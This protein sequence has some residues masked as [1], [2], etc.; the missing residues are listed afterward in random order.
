MYN[1]LSHSQVSRFQTCPTSYKYYYVEKIR[2][3][4]SKAA[5][6]FGT[7]LDRAIQNLLKPEDQNKNKTPEDIFKYFWRFQ[8]VNG[9]REYLPTLLSLVYAKSDFDEDL[10]TDEV[11]EKIGKSREEILKIIAVR[12]E[13]GY[14]KLSDR[15]KEIA[16]HAFWGCLEQKGL[17]MIEAF[18]NK[19]L[20]K[21][22][23]VLSVQEYICLDNEEGDKVI[24]Y[25]D[26]VVNIQGQDKPVIIDLKTSAMKYDEVNSVIYS[27]QLSLYVHAVGKKY[28]TNKAGYIVLNKHI[29]KNKSK[30]CLSCNFDGSGSR[31]KT[32]FNIIEDKRCGGAWKEIINPEV[33]VQFLI[34]EI[35][36]ATVNLV[37][38][39]IDEINYALKTGFYT[40]NL[41]KCLDTYG[42]PC[43][44]LSLCYQGKM[45][46]LVKMEN[47]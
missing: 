26:M 21:I 41:S 27:P 29:I 7:A 9:K 3:T 43:E 20:P 44:Y 5:L 32:C 47:S 42:S 19:V 28:G 1:R 40:K 6:M 37:L 36:E 23:K 30:V 38:D 18:K 13:V 2:P 12:N 15:E 31:H 10:L 24:G 16:N 11:V 45:D 22:T 33:Y 46:N 39:N 35:P 8:E 17:L 34:D 4:V 25:I 14:D